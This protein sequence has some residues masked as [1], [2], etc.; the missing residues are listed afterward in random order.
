MTTGQFLAFNAVLLVSMMSPGPALLMAIHTNL[1]AGRAAGMALG[2]GLGLMASSW[3]LLALVGFA[4]L[5]ERLPAAYTLG[6][7]AGAGY[8]LFLAVRMWRTARDPVGAHPPPARRA[9]GQG[10]LVNL[11]N[12]K[13]FL[14]SAAVLIAIFPGGLD[15]SGSLLITANHLFTELS[16]YAMLG[17]CLTTEAVV[18]RALRA[19]VWIDRG[20]AC[21]L[22]ALGLRILI[23]G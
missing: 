23:G 6:R 11:L 4:A 1:S 8:L 2:C 17:W 14:F 3:T 5:L 21:L 22:G 20:A 18:R 13:A 10:L 19:K 7:I 12:P 9:F 16:F 15:L